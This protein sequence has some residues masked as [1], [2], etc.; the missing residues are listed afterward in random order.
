MR[1]FWA[2]FVARNLEFFRDRGTLIWNIIF[3]VFLIFGFAFAFSGEN[4]VVFKV[5]T[6]GQAQQVLGVETW[7]YLKLVPYPNREDAL[8]KLSHHQIDLVIDYGTKSYI[9]NEESAN[10][11]FFEK[12]ISKQDQNGFLREVIKGDRI[13]YVDWFVPGAIGMNIL[14]GCLFGVGFVIVRYRKNGVL[15]RFKATPLKSMEFVSA[16]VFSRFFIV[17]LMAVVVYVG[18]DL[19]L[20]FRMEGSYLLLSLLTILAIVCH[21]S[22][23]LVF[24]SRLKSE[25]LAGGLMNFLTFPMMLMSGIFFSLEGTPAPL[26]AF[27]RIFP[28]T[29]YIDASRQVMLDGVGF[30][31]VWPSLVFMAGATLLFLLLASFLF[32]WE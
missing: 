4:K 16:Q 17:A 3:P 7:K 27:S 20:G 25:E 26:Q 8:K 18:T 24:A 14:F 32:R 13:R 30:L 6:V 22:L 11:Y 31:T 29:H 9:V 28:L 2:V 12:M 21:I 19:F 5:G 15:K 10:G 23:G 1:R